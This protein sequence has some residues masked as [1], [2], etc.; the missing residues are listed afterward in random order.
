[1]F[2]ELL[3]RRVSGFCSLS[4][5][6]V[7]QLHQHYELMRRWNKVINLTRIEQIE[8]VVD[9]HY[10]ESLFL[11]ANLPAC[12][13]TIADI[14]SGAGFPGL[15]IAVLR[16]ESRVT[17]I[18]SHQRKAVFLKEA[19]RTLPNVSVSSRRAEEIAGRFDCVVSRAVSWQEIEKVAFKL[20]SK[21]SLLVTDFRISAGSG[22]SIETIALPWDQRRS[23]VIVSR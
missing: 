19:C 23:V 10:A 14:G 20:A 5:A 21:L 9:R 17:L 4:P 18:E 16:P 15:P 2:P 1:V 3:L 13:I 8:E 7:D 11:G 22:G 6:Q 12:A